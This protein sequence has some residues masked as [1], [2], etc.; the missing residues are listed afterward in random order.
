MAMKGY[1][2]AQQEARELLDESSRG[3]L[4]SDD[5]IGCALRRDRLRR[6]ESQRVYADHRGLSAAFIARL[7]SRPGDLRLSAV[8]AGL[9]STAY[10]LAVVPDGIKAC[11][12]A[13]LVDRTGASLAAT[14][15]EVVQASGVSMRLFAESMGVPRMTLSRAQNDPT[16]LKLSVVRAVLAAG[17]LSLVVSVRDGG[18]VMQPEDWDLGEIAAQARGGERRLAGHRV[19]VHTP[20]GPR[21]WWHTHEALTPGEV[22]PQWSTVGPDFIPDVPAYREVPRWIDQR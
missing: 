18:M 20:E 5:M 21:W 15:R 14:I 17:R 6:R 11:I 13:E 19:P 7:E 4:T 12:A 10:G 8:L 2:R 16:A 9:E 3:D 22:A 1:R